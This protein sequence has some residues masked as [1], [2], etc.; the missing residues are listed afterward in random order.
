L[1]KIYN[2]NDFSSFQVEIGVEGVEE[3]KWIL[4]LQ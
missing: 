3:I 1:I 4:L 2:E